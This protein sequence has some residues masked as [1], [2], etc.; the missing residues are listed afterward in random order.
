[1]FTLALVR[2]PPTASNEIQY[3]NATGDLTYTDIA[4]DRVLYGNLPRREMARKYVLRAGGSSKIFFFS[5][6]RRHTRLQGDWSSDVCSSDLSPS[7]SSRF[8]F[9]A[10]SVAPSW[11]NPCS[12]FSC[13]TPISCRLTFTLSWAWP[14]SSASLPQPI[15]GFP[16]CSDA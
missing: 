4:G 1:M 13:T 14:P 15:I 7:D 5:S 9:P 3:L 10:G 2:F 11:R 8:S 12:T 6:R 16:R